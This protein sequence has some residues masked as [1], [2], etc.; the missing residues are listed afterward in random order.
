MKHHSKSG[1]VFPLVMTTT[2]IVAIIAASVLSYILYATRSAGGYITE[3]Q[4][5]LSAQTALEQTKI[6]IQNQFKAYYHAYPST[7]HGLAW[8]NSYSEHSV[9]PSGY[10]CSM[11]QQHL[12]NGCKVSLR[13]DNLEKSDPNAVFQYAHLSLQATATAESPAGIKISK[14]IEETVEY[15]LRRSSVFDY[16]YFV[17]NYGWFQGSGCTANGDIR[18]NGNMNLD[19]KSYIN[20]FAYAAP[21]DDIGA[22]GRIN[23]SGGGTTRYRSQSSYWSQ[24]IPQS[25]PTNPTSSSSTDP[26]LMGYES[27][28]GLYSY[29]ENLEMPFLGDLENYRQIADNQNGTIKQNGKT[30]VDGCFSGTGPSGIANGEDQGCLILDGTKK[31]IIIDGPVVVDG[32]VIILGTVKGQGA[33]YAGRN[34]HIIGDLTYNDPP[35]WPKPDNNPENTTK[36]NQSSDLLGLIAKGNIVLGNYTPSSWLYSIKNYIKPPFVKGYNCDPTDAS[37]GYDGYFDGNY[38]SKDG[39]LKV[40][41]VWDKKKKEYVPS[42]TS[43]RKYYESSV[44]DNIIDDLSQSSYISTIDAVLYDNHAIMGKVGRCQFNGALVCRDDGC[45]YRSS[46]KMNW[47]I[48]LGSRSPDGLNFFIYLPMSIATPRVIGWRELT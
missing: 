8:F 35:E 3:T 22:S 30:L 46:V 19:H 33:I 39:G 25:R 31:P 48:R 28:S 42:G 43:D 29:Q 44:G 32:D 13:I 47:D 5:R 10:N 6:N 4:C 2:L 41:Y 40:E 17:N 21:N 37:I 26:Y 16:A 1:F 18:A 45:W 23:V 11:M 15:A 36:K 7:W 14:T 34:I 20:G 24:D 12:L 27:R 9:G 38:T